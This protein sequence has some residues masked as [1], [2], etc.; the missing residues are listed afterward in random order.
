MISSYESVPAGTENIPRP[1]SAFYLYLS[2]K[3]LPYKLSHP[4]MT[5]CKVHKQLLEDWKGMDDDGRRPY[6][7]V[8]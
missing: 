2:E 1:K 4:E 5:M 6:E 8:S 3:R 7:K